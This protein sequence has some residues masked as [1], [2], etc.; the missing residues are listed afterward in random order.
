MVGFSLRLAGRVISV[1][2]QHPSTKAFCADYLS[3]APADFAVS[4]LPGDVRAEQERSARE[5][6]LEGRPV[7]QFSDA[8]LESLAVFRK[9][10][11]RLPE[12]DTMLFH[13]S[14]VA[15]DGRAYL[16]TAKSGTGKST[17]ARLWRELL[18]PRA[19]MVNDDKPLLRFSDAG[20]QVCGTPWNGKHRLGANIAVPL[21]AV[22]LLERAAENR[23]GPV[24][25]REAYP[26]LLQQ[27][28][29]PSD[30]SAMRKTLELVN[31]LGRDTALYRLQCNMDP[32]AA[33][34][35]YAG[36]EGE[37]FG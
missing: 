12:Y 9:I 8:Y 7:R 10:A 27:S 13:G 37:K 24:S 30:P 34:I 5:D 4:V 6:E 35:A 26:L 18:G 22:C 14:A 11:E 17:H 15:V 3:E 29:R 28:Y 16:F 1:T 23:I 21:K 32:S 19:V 20:V 33:A 36:M 2:A 31:R 25:P